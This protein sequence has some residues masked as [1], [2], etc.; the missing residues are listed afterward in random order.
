MSKKL[1]YTTIAILISASMLM[2][3]NMPA[4]KQ[5]VYILPASGEVTINSTQT[6]IA[7][8]DW[9]ACSKG[10]TQD[11][12]DQVVFKLE[13]YQNGTLLQTVETHQ[14]Y[15]NMYAVDPISSCLHINEPQEADWQFDSLNFKKPGTYNLIF[16]RSWN[17]PLTDGGDWDGDGYIDFS[18]VLNF[19]PR[20]VTVNVLP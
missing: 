16:Y 13:L 10:L 8:I 14:G 4:K 9:I 7:R 17:A 15:W 20:Q 3:A 1:F 11:W 18:P 2:A 19:E 6:A 5:P 12:I